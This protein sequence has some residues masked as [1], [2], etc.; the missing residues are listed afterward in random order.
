MTKIKTKRTRMET[1][2]KKETRTRRGLSPLNPR[3]CRKDED[4]DEDEKRI[5]RARMRTKMTRTRIRT[6][7]KRTKRY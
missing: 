5:K 7:I 3:F 6:K 4:E 2:V 1:K